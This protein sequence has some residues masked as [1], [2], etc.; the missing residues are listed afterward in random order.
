MKKILLIVALA[1]Y[2][3]SAL[4]A[5]IVTKAAITPEALRADLMAK[6]QDRVNGYQNLANLHRDLRGRL[7]FH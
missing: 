2:S 3:V 5:N 4:G 6:Y 1:G 7:F